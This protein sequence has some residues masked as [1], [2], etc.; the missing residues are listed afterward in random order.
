LKKLRISKNKNN[1]EKSG[2]KNIERNYNRNSQVRKPKEFNN[3]FKS[4]QEY[5]RKYKKK[6]V[7][8]K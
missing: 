1:H 3:G 8:F 2:I 6:K 7:M 5:S 4:R